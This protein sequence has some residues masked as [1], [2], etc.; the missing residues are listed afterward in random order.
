MNLVI[1]ESPAKGRTLQRIL[2]DDY[3]VAASFGHVRDLPQNALGVKVEKN[4]EPEYVIIPR[5]RK[6]L[7]RLKESVKDAKTVFLA[8]DYDREGEA[9]GWHLMQALGLA[10]PKIK[11]ITFH[12]ITKDAILDAIKNPRTID[13]DLVD[14]QQARRILDRL[15]GYKLS[16]FLWKK[17]FQGLSAGRVQ[18]VAVRLIVDRERE[19]ET[20]KPQ[21]YWTITADFDADG[22]R[23]SAELVEYQGKKLDKL[24]IQTQVQAQKIVNELSV[25]SI[26]YQVS[27]IETKDEFKWAFPPFTTSTL[28]QDGNRRLGFTAKKTMKL[29]QDLYEAGSITYMRTDSTS[30]AW[31][32]VNTTRKLIEEEFGKDYLPEKPRQF[33]TKTLGAQEAHEAIRPTYIA[34]KELAGKWTTDHKKLYELIWRRMVA[35]QMNPAKLSVTT[36][37]VK[38]GDKGLFKATGQTLA[39]DG[40]TKVYPIKLEEKSLPKLTKDEALKLE[41]L[42]PKQHFT[43]PSHR[44]T[45]A[46]LVK[47]L[48]QFGIGRPSTYAPI[49][50]TIQDRGYVRLQNRFFY[51]EQVGIIVTEL[52]KEHFPDIVDIGFTKNMES[53]L[54]EIAE[55]KQKWQQVL[56]DFYGP[57]EQNLKAKEKT[58]EK[59]NVAEITEGAGVPCERC[60]RPMVVKVGRFGRFL[61]CSGY[62]KCKNTKQIVGRTGITCPECKQGELVSRR[63]KKGGR[64]FWGCERYPKCK[65]ASWKWPGRATTE[66]AQKGTE[67]K[68]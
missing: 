23:F 15:V 60:G 13:N 38:A 31:V 32:A 48:E 40:W 5:A 45:E 56:S 49:I 16:P 10:N 35:C 26:Q 12:E 41:K 51:P 2:G 54:D 7:A 22:R 58:V 39:F 36:V 61:A 62:P 29:A 20:F 1:V 19:I 21:E 28:Q 17:V 6:N 11:R 25:S 68:K 24:E 3:K 37:D 50:S 33:K 30:L 4:F 65:Y 34:T 42:E 9:I 63:T 14:A 57:F 53:S 47:A 46:T 55:G 67:P 18:S 59:T 66:T 27:S 8:T 64:N 44:F 43:E 52:L